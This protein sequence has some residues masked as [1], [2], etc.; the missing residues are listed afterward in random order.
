MILYK[1]HAWSRILGPLR[2]PK[3]IIGK[4]FLEV[5]LDYEVRGLSVSEHFCRKE[6]PTGTWS[7]D[8]R[9]SLIPGTNFLLRN[10]QV[11]RPR[12]LIILMALNLVPD[13]NQNCR[14]AQGLNIQHAFEYFSFSP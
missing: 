10:G 6:L 12:W 14:G 11:I 1:A 7:T 5:E 4:I 13:E 8:N 3:C 9:I 2:S